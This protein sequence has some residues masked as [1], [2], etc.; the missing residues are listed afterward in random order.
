M[1]ALGC[2]ARL[3]S[4]SCKR[5]LSDW[6][7]IW[8]TG[9]ALPSSLDLMTH[10][11]SCLVP[12]A[13]KRQSRCPEVPYHGTGGS[14]EY[15]SCRDRVSNRERH[16]PATRQQIKAHFPSRKLTSTHH[17]FKSYV[18]SIPGV[19]LW[20]KCCSCAWQPPEDMAALVASSACTGAS[21]IAS[22]SS[23]RTENKKYV[24]WIHDI[25][26]YWGYCQWGH[27]FSMTDFS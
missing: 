17:S 16:T 18:Q 22:F 1:S 20:L 13:V 11:L 14:T 3:L 21:P 2:C 6:K 8:G 27:A 9:G 7:Q 23:Q 25:L 5:R 12:Q 19:I 15:T 24:V 10:F 26:V 4:V